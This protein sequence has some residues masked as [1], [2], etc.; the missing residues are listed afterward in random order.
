VPAEKAAQLVV[1]LASGSADALSGR[2]LGVA[3]DL[4]KLLKRLEE[5]QRSGLYTLRVRKL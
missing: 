1:Q 4:T 3:D 2:F 5:V